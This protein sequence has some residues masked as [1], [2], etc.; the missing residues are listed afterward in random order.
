MRISL[1]Q[2]IEELDL[3]LRMR[4]Q[5]YGRQVAAGKMKQ[6]EADYRIERL[7]AA[8]MT[9]MWLA[10]QE[11]EIRRFGRLAPDRRALLLAAAEADAEREDG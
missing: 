3:E 9:L 1:N 7:S 6:S 11:D 4:R 10:K 5:V 2:Q 8:M